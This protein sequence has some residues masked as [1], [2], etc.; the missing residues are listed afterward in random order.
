MK[1]L[2]KY[3]LIIQILFGL[4]N[5]NYS[6]CDPEFWVRND[7]STTIVTNRYILTPAVNMQ[8][9]QI[10]NK[11]FVS[12]DNDFEITAKLNFGDNN[13][14]G[15][16]SGNHGSDGIAF[17][18][19][20][21]PNGTSAGSVG[22]GMGYSGI[23]PSVAVEFDTHLNITN[24]SC[25]GGDCPLTFTNGDDK[26]HMA[27]QKNGVGSHNSQNGQVD[28]L[29]PSGNNGPHVLGDIES[30]N[31]F[32]V[33]FVWIATTNTFQVYFD[34]HL[35]T[36]G[37]TLI[38]TLTYDFVNDADIF[39]GNPIVYWGFTAATGGYNNQ[40]EVEIIS[41]NVPL[42]ISYP[43][44]IYCSSTNYTTSEQ[45]HYGITG[46]QGGTFSSSPNGLSI[47]S[48]TGQI[49][50]SA[51]QPGN[52]T[53]TY[54]VD[55]TIPSSDPNYIYCGATTTTIQIDEDPNFT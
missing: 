15:N 46:Q 16:G 10:W 4:G 45:S 53:I 18:L 54:T 31:D 13:G 35:T 38:A 3:V 49:N 28:M 43:Y 23:S 9:G 27:I 30:G 36:V 11:A 48:T 47:N 51:S 21:D 55:N 17:V 5:Y 42:G 6:Q 32:N 34:D 1:K 25:S 44:D 14:D 52:Y 26:D 8:G 20:T 7:A 19:Q 2:F 39:N 12:L 41:A 33:K 29:W 24:S 40:H 37:T 50:A 22:G